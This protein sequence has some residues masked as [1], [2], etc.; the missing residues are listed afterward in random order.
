M[1]LAGLL[2]VRLI[3]RLLM[4]RAVSAY[5]SVRCSRPV[6]CLLGVLFPSLIAR[7]FIKVWCRATWP[8]ARALAPLE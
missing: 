3:F 2:T 6:R 7:C 8:R 5:R 1:A 4:A